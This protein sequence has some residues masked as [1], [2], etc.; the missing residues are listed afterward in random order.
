MSSIDVTSNNA[1]HAGLKGYQ[2]GADSV[3]RSAPMLPNTASGRN[4][5]GQS[6]N[7]GPAV[8]E[9]AS[10]T[11]QVMA[12]PHAID[13]AVRQDDILGSIIDTYA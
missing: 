12:A 5:T 9:F 2:A 1:L 8:V 7:F 4:G 10:G 6:V 13:N 11:L 3:T